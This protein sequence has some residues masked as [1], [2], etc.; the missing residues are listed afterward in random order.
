MNKRGKKSII[1]LVIIIF[2]AWVLLGAYFFQKYDA[3]DSAAISQ[4]GDIQKR[5][6]SYH[7]T[8]QRYPDIGASCG[9]LFA[10]MPY[11][12]EDRMFGFLKK[13]SEQPT[14]IEAIF[15]RP[16]YT[17]TASVSEDGQSYMLRIS[18]LIHPRLGEKSGTVLGCNCDEPNFCLSSVAPSST[19]S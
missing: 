10:L 12:K 11:L 13:N 9:E 16:V 15:H 17:S 7:N 14:L 1:A 8:H 3:W 5:M 6:E 2:L 19:P 4:L 18:G